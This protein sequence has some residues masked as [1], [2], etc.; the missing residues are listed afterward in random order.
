MFPAHILRALECDV[1][2]DIADFH[3]S[4]TVLMSDIVGFTAW[5]GEVSPKTV[6]ESLSAYFQ[7]L[8]DIAESLS[9]Y[10]VETIGD[11]YQAICGAPLPHENHGEVMA[12]FALKMVRTLPHMREIGREDFNIRVGINSGPIATGVIRADRPRWQLFGDT[13][14][15][16]SRMESTSHP[17]RIQVSRSTYDLLLLN[18]R[19]DLERRGLQEIKGKG[20]QETFFLNGER[21][22][23]FPNDAGLKRDKSKGRVLSDAV[24]DIISRAAGAE[25]MPTS[26]TRTIA[27]RQASSSDEADA[28]TD[29]GPGSQRGGEAAPCG[30]QPAEAPDEGATVFLVDDML[31]ILLQYTR[32]LSKTGISVTTARDGQEALGVLKQREFTVVRH[33]LAQDGRHGV[34]AAVPRVGEP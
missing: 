6:I 16:A 8:D 22:G 20:T 18:N 28:G 14:N 26:L 23:A 27:E 32:V 3:T 25:Q 12:E 13:V 29:T 33:Q 2:D 4:V 17:G 9:V 24:G 34:R 15:Y 1:G 5:C 31:S 10:K 7:V 21:E 19:F 11:G 30:A